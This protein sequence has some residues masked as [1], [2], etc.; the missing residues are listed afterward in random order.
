MREKR[1]NEQ[2]ENKR[3]MVTPFEDY[4]IHLLVTRNYCSISLLIVEML[5]TLAYRKR[6]ARES[7]TSLRR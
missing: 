1:H 7:N 6:Q 4:R 5:I 3:F 2:T